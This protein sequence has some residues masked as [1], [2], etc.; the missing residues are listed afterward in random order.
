MTWKA[1][2][3][4][5]AGYAAVYEELV[6]AIDRDSSMESVWRLIHVLMEAVAS[7]SSQQEMFGLAMEIER[8][9]RLGDGY[10]ET[11]GDV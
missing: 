4:Y 10:W 3:E 1:Q 8:A 6:G 11:L 5:V 7:R 2:R 9:A